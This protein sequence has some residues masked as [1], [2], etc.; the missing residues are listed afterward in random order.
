MSLQILLMNLY[1]FLPPQFFRVFVLF[2]FSFGVNSWSFGQVFTAPYSVNFEGLPWISVPAS[3]AINTTT[4][5][6]DTNWIPSHTSGNFRWRILR[7]NFPSSAASGPFGGNP[8]F[9]GNY[10]SIPISSN[11]S[12]NQITSITSPWIDLSNLTNPYLEFY[13]HRHGNDLPNLRVE[14]NDG[15]GWTE[16]FSENNKTHV[17]RYSIYNKFGLNLNAF[18]NLVQIR[19]SASINGCCS[20]AIAIDDISFKE[21]PTCD[22]PDNLFV[23]MKSENEAFLTWPASAGATHYIIYKKRGGIQPIGLPLAYVPTLAEIVDTAYTNSYSLS[24]PVPDCYAYYVRARCGLQTQNIVRGPKIFCTQECKIENLPYFNAL[25]FFPSP[26]WSSSTSSHW[27]STLLSN[28][29]TV[30]ESDPNQV[31]SADSIFLKSPLISLPNQTNRAR[32]YWSR[33]SSNALDS[34]KIFIRIF[35]SNKW[36]NIYSLQGSSFID[37]LASSANPGQFVELSIPIDSMIYGGKIIELS[38]AHFV[39]NQSSPGLRLKNFNVEKA[40]TS[41]LEIISSRFIKNSP[42]SS[43]TDTIGV[44]I[45]NKTNTIYNFQDK[46]LTIWTEFDGPGPKFQTQS[47]SSGSIPPNSVKEIYFGNTDLSQGGTHILTKIALSNSI[48]NYSVYNDSLLRTQDSILIGGG[49]RVNP[50]SLMVITNFTDSLF[51]NAQAQFFPFE[52]VIFTEICHFQSTIGAPAGGYP[53]YMG[54]DDFVEISGPPGANLK[55]YTFERYRSSSSNDNFSFT[56]TTNTFF[57]PQGTLIIGINSTTS[58]SDSNFYFSLPISTSQ[59]TS[60]NSAGYILRK[61]DGTISDAVIYNGGGTSYPFS[62]SSS[63]KNLDWLGL[64]PSASGTSGIR[65][66]GLDSNT[67]NGWVVSSSSN[68]QDPNIKNASIYTP[69]P[70]DSGSFKWFHQGLIYDSLPYTMVGPFNQAGIYSFPAEYQN[71]CGIH[72]DTAWVL[73][74][75]ANIHCDAPSG[76]S[77]SIISCRKAQINWLKIGSDTRI[78]YGPKGFIPGSGKDSISSSDSLIFQNLEPG[79]SY[80]VW[81]KNYCT[82]DTSSWSGPFSF[83]TPTAPKPKAEFSLKQSFIGNQM[84]LVMDASSS[85]LAED[86]FW[87]YSNGLNGQ[88]MKDSLLISANGFLEIKLVVKND[89]G[90]DSIIQSTLVNIGLKEN[91]EVPRDLILYPNPTDGMLNLEFQSAINNTFQLSI[92]DS[93]GLRI[94][95]KELKVR[96]GANSTNFNLDSFSTGLYFIILRNENGV[97]KRK[98]LVN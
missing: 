87:K 20:D 91:T 15:N 46:P 77:T 95:E 37:P 72:Y 63:V 23:A 69:G 73:V 57:S 64:P 7:N 13:Y 35:G 53:S 17:S 43:S 83:T 44:T 42:C 55:G 88:G 51:L 86:Y 74:N 97:W 61:P 85:L 96:K 60:S 11:G 52:D 40:F 3:T 70:Y 67:P 5:E 9:E 98:V 33:D 47:I 94:M 59:L 41:D 8:N 50:D 19:F 16:I 12:G 28:G 79:A 76:V 32:F 62:S 1:S 82:V 6:F 65:L 68:P 45:K 49:F 30:I 93:R 89:C 48:F 38:L 78:H 25:S 24:L 10:L 56:F 26:C 14:I 66:K 39:E 75:I 2:V 92:I 90:M 58:S 54:N 34:M 31:G 36:K 71:T 80:D 84:K 22:V 29:E 4:D 27:R 21:E 18:A 81:L